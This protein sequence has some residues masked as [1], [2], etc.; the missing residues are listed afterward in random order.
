MAFLTGSIQPIVPLLEYYTFKDDIIKFFCINRDVPDSTCDGVC[1]LANQIEQA[2]D[3]QSDSFDGWGTYFPI[4]I[5]AQTD[6][7]TANVTPL[8]D[9]PHVYLT[10]LV[11]N[12]K[13]VEVP[14]PISA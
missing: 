9:Q 8:G 6:I 7:V 11:W 1:Y 3:K 14:P 10:H 2:Q 5:V 4:S 13:M 12:H